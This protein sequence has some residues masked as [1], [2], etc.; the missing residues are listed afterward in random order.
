MFSVTAASWQAINH[1]NSFT[2]E[3]TGFMLTE[4]TSFPRTTI[5]SFQYIA[6]DLRI[7]LLLSHM[8]AP[9][10]S[11]HNRIS[12]TMADWAFSIIWQKICNDEV[13]T[14]QLTAFLQYPNS[15]DGH[16]NDEI[17]YSKTL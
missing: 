4:C 9:R 7:P 17:Y 6:I 15:L 2:V 5:A 3:R 8:H 16:E 12:K 14:E 1:L 13:A 11:Y 10:K